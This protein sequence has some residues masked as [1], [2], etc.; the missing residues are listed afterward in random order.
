MLTPTQLIYEA[1]KNTPQPLPLPNGKTA[2]WPEPEYTDVPDPVCWLCGGE[3]HGRGRPHKDVI[4]KTFTNTPHARATESKSLCVPCAWILAQKYIRNWSLLVVDG[5]FEHPSRERIREILLNPPRTFPWLLSI[6]VSGQ[7]HI[8]F[9]GHI[10]R[11]S[12]DMRVLMEELLVPI[13]PEGIGGWLEPVE[14]LYSGGFSKDEIRR[15]NYQQNR[16]RRFGMRRWRELEDNVAPL[17]GTRM[18]ELAVLV[19]QQRE[20]ESE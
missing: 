20:E 12:R 10:N 16:I 9:P 1:W 18:L 15:G 17:R 4:R 3:T 8:S 7:K 5:R 6:A 14:E 13:P 2:V 19:A 11:S